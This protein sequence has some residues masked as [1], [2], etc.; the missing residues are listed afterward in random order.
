MRGASGRFGQGR[1]EFSG[2]DK[3]RIGLRLADVQIQQGLRVQVIDE[4][5]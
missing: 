4:C 2:G 1:G 5:K 3:L